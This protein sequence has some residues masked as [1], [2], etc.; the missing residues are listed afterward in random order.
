M[1]NNYMDYGNDECLFFFTN[2]QKARML[3]ALNGPRASLLSSDGLNQCPVG[4]EEHILESSL[5]VYPN[6]ASDLI[7]IQLDQK[8]NL[9]TEIRIIDLNGKQVLSE[10][11]V[12]LGH[13][14]YQL[15]VSEL[16]AGTYVLELRS[17][18]ELVT[19]R[20]NIIE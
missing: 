17:E 7:N 11:S 6:P 8:N 12:R 19:R 2:G 18:T 4:V 15:N 1:F 9:P 14:A 3:A 16:K 10:S 13:A 5:N 20:I